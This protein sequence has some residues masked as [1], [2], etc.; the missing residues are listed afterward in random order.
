M[1]K[2]I[3]PAARFEGNVLIPASKSY[4]QR[5]LAC[6]LLSDGKTVVKGLGHSDDELAALELLKASNARLE[7]E[8]DT[9]IISGKDKLKFQKGELSFGESGLSSRMFTPILAT[10]SQP[11]VLTGHGSLSSRPMHIFDSVFSVLKVKFESNNGTLP[12]KLQG[13]LVPKSI[14]LDGSLSSQFI[15]G[16][17]YA[18]AGNPLTRNE[19]IRLKNPTSI[20]YIDLSIDVLSAFGISVIRDNEELIFSGPYHFRDTEVT[21]EGDWSS[22]S[23][24][25]VAAAV[26]G[27]IRLR[28][29]DPE[30][31]QSDVRVLDALKQFGAKVEWEGD[32]VIVSKS[33]CGNFE[34]D[35]THCPDLFPPLAVLGSYGNGISKIHGVHR[36]KSKESDRALTITEELG[37]LGGKVE[38]EGDTMI[39]YPKAKM[40]HSSVSS[41]KDHRIAMACT[42]FALGSEAPVLIEEAEAV[43][44]SFP[45][46]YNF[47]DELTAVK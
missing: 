33:E 45:D 14:E 7:W 30:S 21:I 18:F 10:G 34:L 40:I 29:L 25:L 9:L 8:G 46:F 19:R 27:S 36:L 28:G 43:S 35:A 4:A 15:T 47:I 39:I 22:A 6:A 11:L 5:V 17:M 32:D 31:K 2:L 41:R 12:F 42:I 23:F 20:P 1:N 13:P 3:H 16:F 38:I 26:F 44:K 37:K 24:L